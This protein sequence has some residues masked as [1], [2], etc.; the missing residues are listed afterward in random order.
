MG[1]G[2]FA[3]IGFAFAAVGGAFF[4]KSKKVSE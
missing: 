4:F 2:M 3:L 1:V